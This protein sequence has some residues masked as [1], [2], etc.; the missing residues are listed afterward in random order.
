MP[1]KTKGI[2]K[3][4]SANASSSTAKIPPPPP[5][6]SDEDEEVMSTLS[7]SDED[8]LST[9]DDD[10]NSV[11]DDEDGSS[12][13]AGILKSSA[14]AKSSDGGSLNQI[15]TKGGWSEEYVHHAY[16]VLY[17]T[18]EMFKE[19]GGYEVD[20]L[21][22]SLEPLSGNPILFQTAILSPQFENPL[23]D[24]LARMYTKRTFPS[25]RVMMSMMIR[26]PE[27]FF[28][29][30][31][32]AERKASQVSKK[33]MELFFSTLAELKSTKFKV[34]EVVFI[35][36]VALSHESEATRKGISGTYFTQVFVDEEII[37]PPTK[38]IF[39]PKIKIFSPRE[40]KEFF[41]KET[42]LTPARMQQVSHVDVLMKY[43]GARRQRVVEIIRPPLITSSL[44][45]DNLT[46]AWIF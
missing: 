3:S 37:S 7:S 26:N 45:Q 4:S 9:S 30:V 13:T 35:A 5:P 44:V 17:K 6:S 11:E 2:L 27:G 18:L 31:F 24:I 29:A 21:L 43:L 22:S 10:M 23:R 28:T 19:R 8:D 32:F 34:S 40:T 36:P 25:L 46:Y 41:E 12:S 42:R 1:I 15:K 20:G 14:K 38:C 39:S 16:H 33:L